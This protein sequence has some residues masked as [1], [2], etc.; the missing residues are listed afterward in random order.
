MGSHPLL[1]P[2][3]LH[4]I[5][6]L[7][8]SAFAPFPSL[9]PVVVTFPGSEMMKAKK[10]WHS[11]RSLVMRMHLNLMKNSRHPVMRMVFADDESGGVSDDS[12][13]DDSG[14]DDP[15]D[16]GSGGGGF[17]SVNQSAGSNELRTDVETLQ[18]QQEALITRVRE[19]QE[20]IQTMERDLL[21]LRPSWKT[22]WAGLQDRPQRYSRK[23]KD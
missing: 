5:S 12:G 14:F 19:L 21:R 15:E 2:T 22:P 17:A 4:N 1:E 3:M 11:N 16:S 9:S 10:T 18:A 7:R 6:A 23:L 8:L 13:F 20:I